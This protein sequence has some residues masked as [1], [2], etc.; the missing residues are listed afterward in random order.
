MWILGVV[1]YSLWNRLKCISY[2]VLL[3]IVRK[4]IIK[5]VCGNKGKRCFQRVELS[6]Q[7]ISKSKKMCSKLSFRYNFVAWQWTKPGPSGWP[8]LWFYRGWKSLSCCWGISLLVQKRSLSVCSWYCWM[9]SDP[10][11]HTSQT[12]LFCFVKID[13]MLRCCY[14]GYYKC[15]NNICEVS[16]ETPL[17][18]AACMYQLEATVT[19]TR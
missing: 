13:F 9:I 2:F 1:I 11:L 19:K 17:F 12:K 4:T 6:S 18:P 3:R 15:P 8:V 7:L 14:R 5:Y 10:C 16:L